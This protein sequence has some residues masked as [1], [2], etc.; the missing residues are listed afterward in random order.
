MGACLTLAAVLPLPAG[1][2]AAAN[3]DRER[4]IVVFDD[5]RVRDPHA[6]AREH[7]RRYGGEIRAV[8]E[9]ALRG[10][11]AEM[12][13]GARQGIARDRRV[14]YVELDQVATAFGEVPTGVD[15][16]E[17]D[18]HPT[19]DLD[20]ADE[21]VDVDVAII[22]T[23]SGPHHEL[24]VV[25]GARCTSLLG[26][27]P[28]C[29]NGGYDDDNGHGTHVAGSAAAIDDGAG[30]VGVAPGA[31]LW[32]VKVLDA[33]GAGFISQVVAG[34]D[35]VTARAKTIEVANMSLGCECASR[36]LND[37]ITRSAEAG[38]VYTV[39]A[40]NSADNAKDFS[41]ANHPRVIAVSAMADFDGRAGGGA[42]A[43]CRSDV[44]DSFAD[45]SNYG[46]VVDLAAPGVCITSTWLAGGY[47]TFSGTSMA[48]PHGA[49][50]AALYVV[51][52]GV[53]R[54]PT[55]W[56]TV[57]SGLTGSGW[58][59]PQSDPCGFSAG[60]SGEPMLM[61]GACDTA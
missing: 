12:P 45:F 39:A 15:R 3:H 42:A 23:G 5:A 34:I 47:A 49:G 11:A 56:S 18:K 41:P 6:V 55:R 46:S 19:A 16:V 1:A 37:A 7:E 61:L 59:V 60:R 25:G 31:R 21:R 32:A 52:N 57:R 4:L 40:G 54:S 44:D 14:A 22:D 43:T 9:H 10:Y 58:S 8:Y 20:G 48:S 24:N 29:R 53:S 33:A 27:F 35:W 50:A 13:A 26:L 2:A 30:V 17:A 28:S 36:A 51:A 38:L